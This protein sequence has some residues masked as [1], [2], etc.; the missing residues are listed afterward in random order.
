MKYSFALFKK[1][2]KFVLINTRYW[3]KFRFVKAK[4]RNVLYFV[5]RPEQHHSGLADRLKAVVSLYNHAKSNGY[6]FKFYFETPFV[7]TDFLKPKTDWPLQLE[8]LEYSMCDTKI[9]NETNWHKLPKLI[10]NKQYHCYNYAGNDIPW[11][12]E[13]TGWLWTDLFHELFEP[14]EVLQ[15]AF[16]AQKLP[17]TPY[18]SVQL[19]FVNALERFENT[20]FDNYIEDPVQREELVKKCKR[21][22]EEICEENKGR[23]VY[24]FS[25]SKLFLES[26]SDLPVR[27]LPSDNIGHVGSNRN[28]DVQL[29]TFLDLYVMSKSTAIYRLR[30]KEIYNL[31]CFALLA[32]RI[33]DVPFIDK[34]IDTI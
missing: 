1:D 24:V 18:V 9:I 34:E 15:E 29:K 31:S 3:R 32:A 11:K 30:G 16:D 4:K 20:F 25:D 14:S 10:P 19:R 8:D 21:R 27:T 2:V 12:F 7:L 5:F 13:D 26:L 17:N 6:R 23:F 22:I 28:A 33:G